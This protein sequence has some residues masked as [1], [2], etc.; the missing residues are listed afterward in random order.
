MELASSLKIKLS[1]PIK[2]KS[3]VNIFG[4]VEVENVTVTPAIHKYWDKLYEI[5][6]KFLYILHDFY[7]YH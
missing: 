5:I 6:K 1:F 4:S 7:K 3:F 2:K